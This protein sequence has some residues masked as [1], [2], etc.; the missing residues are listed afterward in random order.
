MSFS[1]VVEIKSVF[2]SPL[3]GAVFKGIPVGRFRKKSF[4]AP[5]HVVSRIPAEGEFW[6]IE[7][8]ILEDPKYGDVVIVTNAFL[9]E[10]PSFNYVGKLLQNHPAFRGFHFGK[11]KVKKLVDASGK[12]ALVDILNKSDVNALIDAGL[13]EPIAIRV[14]D[15]WG[16]LKDETEVATFLHEHKLDS[17]LAKKIVRLCKHDTIKRLKRNPFALIALSNANRR[18]LLTIA[19]V[20]EKLGISLEDERVQIGAVEYAMYKELDTGNTVIHLP[21][22]LR[23]IADALST[24]RSP[25]SP[26]D[27]VRSALAAK[28]VCI[29][30]RD[31]EKYLQA[32][33]VAYIEQYVEERLFQIHNTQIPQ[34]LFSFDSASLKKRIA[35][36]NA[37]QLASGGFSLNKEQNEAVQMALQNRVSVLSGYGG[38]GKTT[39]LRA[40]VRLARESLI[41]VFVCALAGKAANRASQSVGEEASTI[42][43]YIHR[44]N[45]DRNIEEELNSDPLIIVDES[46]MIDMSLICT[47]LKAL[48]GKNVRLLLVG[49]TAQLPPIGFGLFY[50][51]LVKSDVPQTQLVQVH[52]QA[53][54][55]PLHDA[56]MSIRN[57]QTHELPKY[58]GQEE[59]IYLL[60]PSDSPKRTAIELREQLNTMIL[61]PYSSGRYFTSTEMLNPVVQSVVNNQDDSRLKLK[62]G[63]HTLQIGDP[64]IVTKNVGQLGLFNGMT[65]VI[66]DITV[67]GE[68]LC[69]VLF[70]GSDSQTTLSRDQAWDL[71]LQLAYVITIH[72]SQ[73]SEYEVCAII[74]GGSMIEN[75][76]L[77]TAITRT[78][79]LCIVIGTQEMYDSAL[80]RPPRYETVECGFSPSFHSERGQALE[81]P[82]EKSTAPEV[83][84]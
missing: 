62:L 63:A 11:A 24:I 68:T 78:Q 54:G 42:H 60:E 35:A 3:G 47:L 32:I 5:R 52:R 8:Q 70:E 53:D 14:C 39:V 61:T 1:R 22:A 55:S 23:R 18:N 13:S 66:T 10:L 51:K 56:A 80:S 76:A 26:E 82:V 69:T 19:R 75:S 20:G 29:Y 21:K 73:G 79:R 64:V 40:V 81:K 6:K 72:K 84:D 31:G 46:S 17:T 67:E 12:Y 57:R 7:G 34:S 77:Y 27:A 71:G 59:G 33:A 49:D 16:R 25:V 44:I 45:N 36:Y 41:P 74:L 83:L 43:S 65:G 37:K 50:H 2:P 58:E 48:E 30:E 28:A 15:A 38:T 4:R 9:H